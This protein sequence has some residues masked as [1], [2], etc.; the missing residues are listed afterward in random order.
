[1]IENSVLFGVDHIKIVYAAIMAAW[2]NG[3]S[4]SYMRSKQYKV[5]LSEIVLADLA[6]CALMIAIGEALDYTQS[7]HLTKVTARLGKTVLF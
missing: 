4:R 7:S 1:M 5:L 3:V 2:H 6:K